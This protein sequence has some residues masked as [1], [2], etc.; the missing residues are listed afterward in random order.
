MVVMV[1]VQQSGMYLIALNCALIQMVK[2]V[3]FILSLPQ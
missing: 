3:D 1:V 2:P